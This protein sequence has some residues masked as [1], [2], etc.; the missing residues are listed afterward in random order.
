MP[1]WGTPDFKGTLFDV[2]TGRM[3][4]NNSE[5]DDSAILKFHSLVVKKV[6]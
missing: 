6:L 2:V 4:K 5:C 1:P 3:K